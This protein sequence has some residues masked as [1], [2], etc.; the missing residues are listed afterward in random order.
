MIQ[1]VLHYSAIGLA[2]AGMGIGVAGAS[3]LDLN[4]TGPD[5]ENNIEMLLNHDVE[6]N[7]QNSVEIAND[8]KQLAESGIG[9]ITG[10]ASN[11]STLDT[12]IAIADSIGE[13]LSN[14][15]QSAVHEV[16]I[17]D[18]GP[19]SENQVE[20]EESLDFD[21]ANIH[22]LEVDNDTDQEA[23]ANS[24]DEGEEMGSALNESVASTS[25]KLS[26]CDCSGLLEANWDHNAAINNTGPSSENEIEIDSQRQISLT[27]DSEIEVSSALQ[28]QAVSESG[29]ENS[30]QAANAGSN[31]VTVGN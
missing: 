12:V 4:T 6:I 26:N 13:K 29:E 22:R 16:L 23:F 3:T 9:E 15:L 25:I 28:Q 5:S 8:V 21:L 30:G 24:G 2:T 17:A 27:R 14:L 11:A 10:D 31:K 7:N 19:D 18:T 1:K 20:I